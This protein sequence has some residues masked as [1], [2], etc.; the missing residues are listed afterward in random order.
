MSICP[1]CERR[2]PV[3]DYIAKLPLL[4]TG[5]GHALSIAADGEP[6]EIIPLE[7]AASKNGMP[8]SVAELPDLSDVG[9]RASLAYV[10]LSN[11][12]LSGALDAE[13]NVTHPTEFTPSASDFAIAIT[14]DRELAPLVVSEKL[15]AS[16]FQLPSTGPASA[17]EES[18]KS[19][20]AGLLKE[21]TSLSSSGR[22]PE[23][24]PAP[25]PQFAPPPPAKPVSPLRKIWQRLT[26]R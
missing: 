4:C 25:Q 22:P 16:S 1:S 2:R 20:L 21:I 9:A 10:G 15:S 18:E 11:A 26:R 5:C 23:A 3:A 13:S 14:P 19:K 12:E 24:P 8:D 17:A 6:A 7:I